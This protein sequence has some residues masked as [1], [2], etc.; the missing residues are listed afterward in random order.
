MNSPIVIVKNLLRH[1]AVDMSQECSFNIDEI[2]NLY[3]NQEITVL[4]QKLDVS[5]WNLSNEKSSFFE[6][7]TIEDY[8][9]YHTLLENIIESRAISSFPN[10]SES[11]Q[12]FSLYL[13][14]LSSGCDSPG[15]GPLPSPTSNKCQES[16]NIIFERKD[17]EVLH[18]P[19]YNYEKVAASSRN[20]LMLMKQEIIRDICREQNM[21]VDVIS[22]RE[23]RLTEITT[24]ASSS[25][26][27]AVPE[28]LYIRRLLSLSSTKK[29][30][31]VTN[32]ECNSHNNMPTIGKAV[33][34]LP[35]LWD[36]IHQTEFIKHNREKLQKSIVQTIENFAM[37]FTEVQKEMHIAEDSS[38][39]DSITSHEEKIYFDNPC[40]QIS[41]TDTISEVQDDPKDTTNPPSSSS[42][43]SDLLEQK[44]IYLNL[45]R[46][47]DLL[48]CHHNEVRNLLLHEADNMESS[49]GNYKS[50][51]IEEICR[52]CRSQYKSPSK[53]P[54]HQNCRLL[55]YATLSLPDAP[56]KQERNR[57]LNIKCLECGH[58]FLEDILSLKIWNI[59]G[60]S[61]RRLSTLSEY[62]IEI[63]IFGTTGI[64]QAD[65]IRGL[66]TIHLQKFAQDFLQQY[67]TCGRFQ[68][69][70]I[71]L[72]QH[73][74]LDP[75]YYTQNKYGS[76]MGPRDSMIKSLPDHTTQCLNELYRG[77]IR[78]CCN[79][80]IRNWTQHMDALKRHIPA[81][82]QFQS[83]N[84]ILGRLRQDVE[85]MNSPQVYM[86][87]PGVWTGGHEENLR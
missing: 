38:L 73:N 84:D 51:F 65:F 42:L 82:M 75:W 47:L 49:E 80:D 72:M 5:G 17:R 36:R 58:P 28:S 68:E 9:N 33:H 27:Q 40:H 12:D 26:T 7:C 57:I 55:A 31:T 6:R 74:L 1:S 34:I 46:N 61:I 2:F 23:V 81:W 10:L 48:T 20:R 62:V 19:S 45:K 87:V 8:V 15:D 43:P 63:N 4:K 37:E 76:K 70:L 11:Q 86:K 39:K 41:F 83:S 64:I 21:T 24:I 79:V 25:F 78:F 13:K 66:P 18:T 53:M 30:N 52:A 3:K 32:I 54:Y 50:C 60:T 59:K 71:Y 14:T 44:Q 56:I 67:V 69:E 16:S 77:W 35:I 22:E 29:T 85:G